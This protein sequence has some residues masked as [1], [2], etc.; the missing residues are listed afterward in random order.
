MPRLLVP[1]QKVRSSPCVRTCQAMGW[2]PQTLYAANGK[3]AFAI[4]FTYLAEHADEFNFYLISLCKQQS[5]E[6]FFCITCSD[7]P[8]YSG[9]VRTASAGVSQP[10][11][12]KSFTS[13]GF[14]AFCKMFC[15]LELVESRNG[16]VAAVLMVMFSL[17]LR[18]LCE[19]CFV[20]V[21]V[22][23][24]EMLAE[25]CLPHHSLQVGDPACSRDP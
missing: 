8:Y 18:C 9:T 25:P 23:G 1:V 5:L 6:R 2:A 24:V 14:N 3:D 19:P 21:A 22:L 17:G 12:L 16:S 10:L 7:Y 15:R 13:G 11:H 4:Q 20:P